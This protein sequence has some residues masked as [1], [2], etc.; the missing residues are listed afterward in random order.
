LSRQCSFH[1]LMLQFFCRFLRWSLSLTCHFHCWSFL[2]LVRDLTYNIY[3]INML[4]KKRFIIPYFCFFVSFIRIVLVSF[5]LLTILP[6]T[7]IRSLAFSSCSDASDKSLNCD[8]MNSFWYR[9]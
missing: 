9:K 6:M 3:A 2:P 7:A 4:S 1:L 8:K 5:N